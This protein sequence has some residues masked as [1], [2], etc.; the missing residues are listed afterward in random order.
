MPNASPTVD[1]TKVMSGQTRLFIAAY[2]PSS[3]PALPADTVA[4][5]GAWPVAWT[6]IGA[7]ADGVKQRFN[8]S[9]NDVRIEESALPVDKLPNEASLSF[10]A[11]L[12]QDTLETIKLV[13][14]GGT[15][16]IQA[17]SSG[18][19]GK[20]TLVLNNEFDYLV[21]GAESLNPFGFWRRL[22][23]PKIVSVSTAETEYRRSQGPRGYAT[24]FDSLCLLSDI[25][26]VE[27]SAAA[28]P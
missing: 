8:R 23:V 22:L 1:T 6:P 19:I 27:Q 11:T 13:Y 3:P 14:G 2:N 20:R 18:V 7:T 26:I 16:T 21:L 24:S 10:L 9:S 12:V 28:L 25:T 5:N 4:L 17:A 15:I